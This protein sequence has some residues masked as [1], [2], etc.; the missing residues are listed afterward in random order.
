MPGDVGEETLEI[1]AVVGK[2]YKVS[3]GNLRVDYGGLVSELV[4][5]TGINQNVK[6]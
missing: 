6:I 2:R 3:C 1:G 4:L 5:P